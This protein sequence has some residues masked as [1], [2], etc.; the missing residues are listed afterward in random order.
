MRRESVVPVRWWQEF[1]PKGQ[2]YSASR[3]AA[4]LLGVRRPEMYQVGAHLDPVDDIGA[5]AILARQWSPLDR[6]GGGPSSSSAVARW[7]SVD[8]HD[9]HG[10]RRIPVDATGPVRHDGRTLVAGLTPGTH[11]SSPMVRVYA[12]RG[13]VDVADDYLATL[14]KPAVEDQVLRGRML[15]T[16]MRTWLRFDVVPAPAATRE[17]VHLPEGVWDRLTSLVTTTLRVADAV[18]GT[19]LAGHRGI[20]LHGPPGTGKSSIGRVLARELVGQ[21]TVIEVAGIDDADDLREVYEAAAKLAPTLVLIEDVDAHAGRRQGPAGLRLSS[22]LNALDGVG[23]T[24]AAVVTIMTTNDIDALDAAARRAGRID[25]VVEVPLPT[26]QAREAI[27]RMLLDGVVHDV[28]LAAAASRA[29]GLTAADLREAV[30]EVVFATGGSVTGPALDAEVDGR[31]G[32]HSES[33]AYL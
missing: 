9:G 4:R 15:R 2:G 5:A 24:D 10:P 11:I 6:L 7:T 29:D 33:G 8:L 19:T 1:V 21:A 17:D 26:L 3:F 13:D 23:T 27:L 18:S 16:R 25:S 30:R 28:D 32:R 22:F 12:R 14:Q 20:V 31:I